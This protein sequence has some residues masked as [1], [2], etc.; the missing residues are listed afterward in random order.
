MCN[1]VTS[2]NPAAG[3]VSLGPLEFP[4]ITEYWITWDEDGARTSTQA[5]SPSDT[6]TLLGSL[7]E[8]HPGGVLRAHQVTVR[9]TTK[10]LD[11]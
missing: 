8:R 7:R 11:W 6:R 1:G 5:L 2:N 10:T 9:R 4:D 3:A